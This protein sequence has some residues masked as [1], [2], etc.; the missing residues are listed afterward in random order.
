MAMIEDEFAIA[1]AET[2]PAMLWM[3]DALGR[4]VFL[5]SAL[6]RFWGVDPQHLD[7]FDWTSTLHPDD[8]ELLSKPFG[9]AMAAHTPFTIE[10]RYKRADGVFRIMR[11]EANPRFGHDGAFLGMTGLNI[12][13]TEQRH[14]EQ[15][16]RYLMG[17]LNHRTKNLLAVVMAIARATAKS[18]DPQR[19][20]D[21]FSSR[22][23]GLASSNDLL[24]AR[25]WSSVSLSDLVTSQLQTI[26]MEKD[27]RVAFGGPN[28]SVCP[29]HAQTVGMALHE[30]ATNSL[31]YGALSEPH[32]R[33]RV[34]WHT[35]G[36]EHWRLEW[37]ETVK[38]TLSA[39]ERRGFGHVVMVDMVEHAVGGKVHLQFEPHGVIWS[40]DV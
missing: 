1:V 33:L 29:Q 8:I 6:R 38:R 18:T 5:N 20:L 7:Q 27:E 28:I 2:T 31:K 12:D 9:E 21:T 30:L 26:S 19:F 17:E 24:V 15:Q 11:T 23:S 22:L 25:D 4:C 35:T 32:G 36:R 13:V 34:V 40:L 16:S 37:R 10:A 3:G 39:P 14:A